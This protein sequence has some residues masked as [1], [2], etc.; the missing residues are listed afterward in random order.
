MF[1]GAFGPI[2]AE[3]MK[4]R[5]AIFTSN[6]RDSPTYGRQ[7]KQCYSLNSVE[8]TKESVPPPP[9]PQG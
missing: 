4:D 6:E 2:E 3:V 9:L 8:V 1:F 5:D 7:R